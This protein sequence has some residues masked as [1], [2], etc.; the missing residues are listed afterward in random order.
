MSVR[1]CK[2]PLPVGAPKD[3][4][5]Y[6]LKLTVFQVPL[7]GFSSP[8]ALA[9]AGVPVPGQHFCSQI[10]LLFYKLPCKLRAFAE[11]VS[12][13]LVHRDQLSLLQVIEN[14]W[15]RVCAGALYCLKLFSSCVFN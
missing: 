9:E 1:G 7:H 15:V 6:G 13:D 3:L 12:Y 2:A 10:R 8:V 5:L 11:T 14:L 4:K